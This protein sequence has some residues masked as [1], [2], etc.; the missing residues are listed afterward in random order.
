MN[1]A[2]YFTLAMDEEIR[3]EGM[4]GSLCGVAVE[5]DEPPDIH[6]LS[7]RIGRFLRNFPTAGAS[8]KK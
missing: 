8:L 7:E 4:P 1:P 5:L 6:K 3:R 2:D